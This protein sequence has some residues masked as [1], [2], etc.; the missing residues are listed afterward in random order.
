MT[1]YRN[2]EIVT[3]RTARMQ[4]LNIIVSGVCTES[5]LFLL[6]KTI[7]GLIKDDIK[8]VIVKKKG[9]SLRRDNNFTEFNKIN[10]H[11]VM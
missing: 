1:R 7:D 10:K 5:E 8:V 2:V 9:Y 6:N 11:G 3:E 4:G